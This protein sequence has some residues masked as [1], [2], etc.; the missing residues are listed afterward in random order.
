MRVIVLSKAPIPGKVK[1]RLMPAYSAEQA[2]A[3]QQLMTTTVIEKVCSIYSDVWLAV[4]E[5][6]H[7]FFQELATTFEIQVYSQGEG[8]LGERMQHLMLESFRSNPVPILFLGSDS[9]HVN[10]ER[11]KQADQHLGHHDIVIG[12]VED[13]G[14]DLIAFQQNHPDVL[15]NI[16]WSTPS[17]RNDTV[18][19]INHLNLSV[20]L[21]DESFDLDDANDLARALPHTW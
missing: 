17:V 4:D 11:Y 6:T 1:T 12:P 20:H 16:P 15:R 2:A 5:V 10:P 13:G 21:L 9:P 14:Y 19:N 8:T 18:N 3:L 7:P